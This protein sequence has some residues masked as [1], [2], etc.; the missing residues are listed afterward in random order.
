MMLT[1]DKTGD[2]KKFMTQYQVLSDLGFLRPV[3]I[4]I[5]GRKKILICEISTNI[6]HIIYGECGY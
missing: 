1:S 2:Y 6:I 5:L 3:P 4:L